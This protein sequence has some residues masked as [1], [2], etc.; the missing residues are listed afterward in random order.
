MKNARTAI[1]PVVT[2]AIAL[3][4]ASIAL[5]I[6]QVTDDETS[7]GTGALQLDPSSLD[8]AHAFEL[9][10]AGVGTAVITVTAQGQAS[11]SFLVTVGAPCPEYLWA[12]GP[13]ALAARLRICTM[14]WVMP[15]G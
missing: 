14:R 3:H 8:G 10:G 7:T 1:I 11:S 12:S 9:C 2:S 5:A 13:H 4:L 15:P 6:A